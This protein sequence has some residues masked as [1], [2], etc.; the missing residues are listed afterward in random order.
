MADEI[1]CPRCGQSQ[2]YVDDPACS[3]IQETCEDCGF[4]F[5]VQ[6]EYVPEF[7]VSCVLHNFGEWTAHERRGKTIEV[8]TCQYC[9]AVEVKT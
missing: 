4:Q 8:R 3:E 5:M 1:E 2:G 7:D 6:V 9:S